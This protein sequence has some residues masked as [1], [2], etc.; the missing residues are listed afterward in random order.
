MGYQSTKRAE[1]IVSQSEWGPPPIPHVDRYASLIEWLA[2]RFHAAEA[3]LVPR[4]FGML[5]YARVY[6][7]KRIGDR[8]PHLCA[9]PGTQDVTGTPQFGPDCLVVQPRQAPVRRAVRT[10]IEAAAPP[11]LDLAPGEMRHSIPCVAHVPGVGLT[12][13]VGYQKRRCGEAQIGE[14]R[15]RILSERGVAVVEGQ[16]KRAWGVGRDA[17]E[18]GDRQGAP[19]GIRQRPH[20]AG[21][22]RSPHAGNPQFERAADAM[23]AQD[24]NA[25]HDGNLCTHAL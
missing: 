4:G 24:G 15:I 10:K 12:D 16:Q 23:I 20:L 21:E 11:V 5:H 7:A 22:Y 13:V 2:T 6:G 17:L 25:I 1:R 14:H 9:E 3:Q 8:T 18:L 19:A